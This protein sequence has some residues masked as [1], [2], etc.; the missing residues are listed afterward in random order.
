MDIEKFN[1][2][3]SKYGVEPIKQSDPPID[4]SVRVSVLLSRMGKDG[5]FTPNNPQYVDAA[6]DTAVAKAKYDE[7]VSKGSEHEAQRFKP[8]A[9]FYGIL[10]TGP[11]DLVAEMLEFHEKIVGGR[12]NGKYKATPHVFNRD[13]ILEPADDA[14]LIAPGGWTR[15]IGRR[16]FPTDT[17]KDECLIEN[18]EHSALSGKDLQGYWAVGS[19]PVGKQRIV[20]RGPLWS[21]ERLLY[22]YVGRGRSCSSECVG[23]LRLREA[24]SGDYATEAEKMRG[25]LGRLNDGLALVQAEIGRLASE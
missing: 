12:N 16:G 3:A 6:L 4:R 14:I 15:T 13:G 10:K 22:A 18:I 5:S 9:D 7:L 21:G 2:E 17:S 24:M 23:A 11:L 20:L 19:D 25:R 1:A 8:L